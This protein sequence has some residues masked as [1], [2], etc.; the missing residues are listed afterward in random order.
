MEEL[1]TTAKI[2]MHIMGIFLMMDQN[3]LE[4]DFVIMVCV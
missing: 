4:K 1:N 3:Q 2:V